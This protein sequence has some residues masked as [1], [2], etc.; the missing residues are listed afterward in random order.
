[1]IVMSVIASLGDDPGEFVRMEWF[2]GRHVTVNCFGLR[3]LQ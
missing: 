2:Y 1:M 3:C